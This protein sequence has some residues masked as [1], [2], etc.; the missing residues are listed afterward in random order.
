MSSS[1]G[2]QSD[3]PPGIEVSA[4]MDGVKYSLRLRPC[5]LRCSGMMGVNG[6]TIIA[7]CKTPSCKNET[8][9]KRRPPSAPPANSSG[10]V[11][12][13]TPLSKY[14]RKTANARERSR[15]R[16]LN[17]AFENLKYCVP[18]SIMGA[19]E[20]EVTGVVGGPDSQQRNE[21]LTKI[22]TLRL[23]MQYIRLL[24]EALQGSQGQI[25]EVVDLL[26]NNEYP[27]EGER[28]TEWERGRMADVGFKSRRI[29]KEETKATGRQQ[30]R[31]KRKEI[32]VKEV[33]EVKGSTTS[34]VRSDNN[35]LLESG[36]DTDLKLLIPFDLVDSP[37]PADSIEQDS[38]LSYY[39]K[40][41]VS[42][43]LALNS[44]SSFDLFSDDLNEVS[45][46]ASSLSP[47]SSSSTT[48]TSAS[49]ASLQ[50]HL[51]LFITT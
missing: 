4:I 45:S 7:N 33:Q 40:V 35:F 1:E 31:R 3:T 15:M 5:R 27:S 24:T 19:A 22:T 50:D 13:A 6:A 14:R 36:D 30:N 17:I 43:L 18:S 25:I 11:K 51:N 46:F 42:P 10:T 9:S 16:E 20:R 44:F 32:P 39:D 8:Y 37:F 23:A 49:S 2:L 48:S 21:K 34:P 28:K 26:N 29:D 12:R 38:L 41:D 47:S